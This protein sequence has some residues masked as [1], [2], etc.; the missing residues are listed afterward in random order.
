MTDTPDLPGGPETPVEDLAT[1]GRRKIGLAA[2]AIMLVHFLARFGGLI[3]KI[4]LARFFGTGMMGDAATAMQRVFEVI[5]YIPEELLTHSLLPVFTKLRREEGE[6]SAWRMASITGTI[7]AVLLVAVTLAAVL[8]TEPLVWLFAK[9]FQGEP[10]KFALT[11][12]IVRV[13]MLGLF[14][15]S[16]G[17]LTYVLLN[18]YKRFVTPALGDVAQ[19]AGIIIGLV[20]VCQGFGRIHP[21]GYAVGFILG[22]VF[23]L[24]T[25]LVALG[26]K[27]KLARPGL[28]LRNRGVRELGVLMIPL[29]AGTI[30]SKVREILETNIASHCLEGTLASLDY[31]RKVVW[32]PVNIIPYALGI[33]LFPFLAEWAHAKD[34]RRVTEAFL[35]ASRLMVFVFLPLTV[36]CLM[37]GEEVITLLYKR[38]SFSEG[39]VTMTA[40]PFAVYALGLVF[41]ALEIIANQVYYAHRDTKTPF[42]LGLVASTVQ[43]LI[44][45]FAGLVLGLNNVGIALG[46][47]CGK[48]VKVV[49]QWVFLRSRLDGFELDKLAA[50][51]VK[52]GVASAAMGV[53]IALVKGRAPAFIDL[54]DWKIALL[55]VGAVGTAG[56]VVYG[57]VS[58]AL[59]TEELDL[60]VD[61]LR[62]KL[63]RGRN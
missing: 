12:D 57:A 44:A 9:G 1:T 35:G 36:A 16:I 5:Y 23:K 18:A 25:H 49:T 32:M 59:K 13:A 20:V 47:T 52:A 38:G 11:V 37:L 15:T 55:F 63:K 42:Y 14:C 26:D 46:L 7:Q 2:I 54:D 62:R 53:T 29:I 21:I 61:A 24:I 34:R 41:Y 6:S 31:A 48:A 40:A 22:G 4:F 8:F 27:V 17:S 3:Q 19:K 58:A 30:V 28:D 50:L 56:M 60:F 51:L 45:Y 43:I 39:S 33:A 10:E